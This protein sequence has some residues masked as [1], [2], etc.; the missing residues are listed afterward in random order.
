MTVREML[1]KELYE[2]IYVRN[3]PTKMKFYAWPPTSPKK[4]YDHA[5][6]VLAIIN[7]EVPL[8]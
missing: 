2:R 4:W 7:R 8:A 1:A 5:D 6:A 3:N